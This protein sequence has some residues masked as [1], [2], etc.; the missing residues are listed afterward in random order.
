MDIRLCGRVA[1]AHEGE[2]LEGRLPGRQGRLLLAYLALGGGRPASRDE[3]IDVVW[4]ERPPAN[5]GAALRTTL[6]RVRGALPE[7]AIEGRAEV[8]LRLGPEDRL[9]VHEAEAALR[10][11]RVAAARGNRRAAEEAACSVLEIVRAPLLPGY[12]GS[13]LEEWRRRLEGLAVE[14]LEICAAGGVRGEDAGLASAEAAARELVE[15][16]PYRESGY[17]RLMEVQSARGNVAEALRVYEQLRTLLREELGTSPGPSVKALHEQL[18]R[19]EVAG[20]G[21]A[22]T[23]AARPAPACAPL[24]PPRPLEIRSGSRFVGR[25]RELARLRELWDDV[26]DGRCSGVFVGG[27]AGIGK[28]RLAAEL[29]RSLRAEGALVL[30]GRCDDGLAVPYQPFLEALRP[31]ARALGV[32]R[33]KVDLGRLAPELG[34]LLPELERLG[35]PLRTDPESER[36]AL[37]EAITALV[38]AAT[39]EQPALLVLDD[40]HWAA[41]PTLLLLRHLLRSER[42]IR[43]L[44]FGSYRPAEVDPGHPLAQLRA[45]LR[46]DVSPETMSIPGL[47]EDDVATLLDE[48]VTA[49][50][51]EPETMNI[52]PSSLAETEALLE[53]AA[54]AA[55]GEPTAELVRVL[56]RHT[57]GNPFFIGELLAHLRESGAISRRSERPIASLVTA[58]LE[59]PEGLRQVVRQRVARLPEPARLTLSIAAVAGPTFS[60]AL[61]E[62]V[63][64]E[65]GGGLDALDAALCAGLLVDAGPGE[66]GFA[67]A[68]VRQTIY[69]Q[70]SSSRRM[71]LH[72]RLGEA[73]ERLPRAEAHVEALAHHFA[74]AAADGQAEKAI[75]YAFAAGQSATAR[76]GY[77]EAAAHYERGLKVF[78]LAD[79]PDDVRRC[80]LLLALGEVRWSAGEL[81]E[82]RKACLEAAELAEAIADSDRLARAALAFG[83][84]PRFEVGA[85]VLEPVVRLLE[86]AL[87]ALGEEQSALRARVLG[88]LAA[89]RSFARPEERSPALARQA[90]AIARRVGDKATLADVLATSHWAT[91]ALDNVEERLATAKELADLA[92][93]LNEGKLAALAHSLLSADLL[94]LGEIERAERELGALETLAE[95]LRQRYPRFLAALGRARRAYLAGRLEECEQ[96]AHEA[97][98]LG[99]EGRDEYAAHVVGA[100]IGVLRREQGRLGELVEGVERVAERYPELPSW[101]CGLAYVY[102]ELGR[103]EEARRELEALARADFSDLPRDGLWLT[104]MS[105]LSSVVVFLGDTRRARLLYDLLLPYAGRCAVTLAVHCE[106]SVSRSLGLLAST[107]SRV[108]VAARHFEDALEMNTRIRSPLWVA[109]TRHDYARML[110][111]RGDSADR[112]RASGLLDEALETAEELRLKA[113]AGRAR[114]LKQEAQAAGTA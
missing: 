70:L 101:R 27:E 5:P 109:H 71:R 58:E 21:D 64:G 48:A 39:H 49:A 52:E 66:Y 36:F 96:L 80:D 94:E 108:E 14:A 92:T 20:F 79:Q 51:A 78:S 22:S 112:V 99:L 106:G 61:L 97:L 113:L 31:Y 59:V 81:E 103:E 11:A 44:V 75:A 29:A 76:L 88:H 105:H 86:R 47:G 24:A 93:E 12:H 74:E 89:A 35:D 26:C 8:S 102:G 107:T 73:L 42:P 50:A 60:L 57:G 55:P 63:V 2:S 100:Q 18:L 1:V 114:T 28:T 62:P 53:P 98:A 56:R 84:P 45:D 87:A 43:A 3:L 110:L 32:D 10:R 23:A 17:L 7:G 82:A 40:L 6:S 67:H 46:R 69:G 30:Y 54:T 41:R 25:D 13:W 90:L 65:H 16:E 34:R 68:L 95:A 9:D 15:R 72:R 4:Q 83:G 104:S 19:G 33:L 111:A 91:R 38:E 85:A 37:F 77:E